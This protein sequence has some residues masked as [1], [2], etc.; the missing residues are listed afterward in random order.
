MSK[1]AIIGDT[2][3]GL[4]A[5][6]PIIKSNVEEAQYKYFEYL[7]E[8]FIANDVTTILFTG[9]IHDTRVSVDVKALVFTRRMM[10]TLLKDFDKHIVAGNH[11]MYYENVNDIS[12]L[13]LFE[14]IPNLTIHREG[15]VKKELVGKTWYFMPWIVPDAEEKTKE[16]LIQLSNNSPD[17]RKNTVIFG[18]FDM[19][20]INMEGGQLS[21]SGID[22]NM[23]LNAADLTISGH[24]HGKSD[25]VKSGG[26]IRYV[27]S[28]YPL[29]F[30]NVDSVH[31]VWLMDENSM[32]F[33]ENK[34]SPT[35]V[36]IYD[37]D[38]IDSFGDLSNSFVRFY[39]ANQNSNE[40][41]FNLRLKMESKKPLLIMPI[42][43]SIA[44]DE[45]GDKT[46]SEQEATKIIGM[47]TYRLSE[48]YIE[49]NPNTLPVLKLSD[50][51]VAEIL[52]QIKHFS[53]EMK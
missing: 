22:P 11:D 18:H 28:P 12:S 4:K 42:P 24:Y 31:G 52:K 13:E 34:I 43:Y 41:E 44:V 40:E 32:E 50:D 51:P 8:Y 37:T 20:G 27:G 5:V 1:I 48:L 16:F 49:N 30:S 6:K 15:I 39:V 7:K 3:F 17:I 14:D 46:E 29:S 36:D 21:T 10:K 33:I 47:D 19:F 53:N 26:L 38:D 9:D 35:F 45:S 25:T 2:H 23:F